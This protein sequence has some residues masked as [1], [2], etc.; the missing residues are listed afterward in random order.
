MKRVLFLSFICL[1][2]SV[3]HSQSDVSFIAIVESQETLLGSSESVL[4]GK[5]YSIL[6]EAGCQND[7]C[8]SRFVIAVKPIVSSKEIVP[9]TP[10]RVKTEISL[11][12][13]IG[14]VKTGKV[15]KTTS[16]TL[17]GIGLNEEK[18]LISCF[19][20]LDKDNAQL[21]IM[22]REAQSE[23]EN[24]YCTHCDEIIK[25]WINEANMDA[26]ESSIYELVSIPNVCKTCYE[27]CQQEAVAIYQR[28]IENVGQDLYAKA[29]IEWMNGQNSEAANRVAAIMVQI[30][31]RASIYPKVKELQN[32]ITQ[33]LDAEEKREWDLYLKKDNDNQSF[34]KSIV[35]AVRDIGVAWGENQPQ[36]ISRTIIRTWF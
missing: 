35:E 7:D 31:P 10:Q 3:C 29:R 2:T 18:S 13:R 34:K 30:D 23:I 27:R 24:Y 20:N 19:N 16:I 9:T 28:H 1:L 12:I 4:K 17:K 26:Y 32:V 5:I 6:A 15:F 36:S 11:L 21:S 33:K 14:D 25:R 22:V 8:N